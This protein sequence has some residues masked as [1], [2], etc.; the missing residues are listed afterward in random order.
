MGGL[1]DSTNVADGEVAIITP[2][3]M[4]HERYLG[5]TLLDIASVKAG[6]IKDGATLVL[7]A[8]QEDV[9]GVVLAAAAEQGA[10][11]VREGV[12]IEVGERQVAVGGQLIDAADAR[13]HVHGDLPA[14]ARRVPGAQRPARPRRRR[15]RC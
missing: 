15:R 12:D 11:V 14:A 3:S 7:A 4:D 8:Q 2:I 1:W 5:D 10:R 6:I 13:R 9:E